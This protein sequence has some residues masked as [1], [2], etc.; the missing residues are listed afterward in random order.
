MQLIHLS[1][2]LLFDPSNFQHSLYVSYV[3][4][5]KFYFIYSFT[6]FDTVDH[7]ILLDRLGTSFG[8]KGT[9]LAWLRSFLTGR[10]QRVFFNG[11][12]SSTVYITTDVPLGSVLGPLL[13]ILYSAD[14]PVIA[15]KHGLGV[16]C[17]ADDG[18][19]YVFD[20][21]GNAD[22]MVAL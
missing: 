9:A 6:A 5:A 21:A 18:Q 2:Y 1:L 15:D 11:V 13:F 22:G 12:S 20:K 14:L 8:I 4:N 7:S 10:K 19:I 16:H 3:D 17:Y